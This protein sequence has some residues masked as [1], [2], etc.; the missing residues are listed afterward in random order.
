[1]CQRFRSVL[2]VLAFSVVSAFAQSPSDA[3]YQAIRNNDLST[4]RTLLKASD[5]NLKDQKETT[6]LMYAAAF[7]SLDAMK[8]LVDAGADVNAK[9]ALAVSPLL[10]CAGDLEK[11]RLLVEKD[12]K[13]FCSE[14]S[15]QIS[16]LPSTPIPE[17]C[18][19][20]L[21]QDGV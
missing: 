12:P 4:L 10:W 16:P 18:E 6:P 5:V 3:F 1:M 7:G 19:P 11:V 20:Q 13:V 2:S 15:S 17:V 8:I 21:L 14:S 9:N